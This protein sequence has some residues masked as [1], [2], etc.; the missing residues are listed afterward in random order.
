MSRITDYV[1]EPNI[2]YTNGSFLIKVKVQDDYKYKKYLVSENIK[3]KTISGTTFTLTDVKQGQPGSILQLEGNTT[4]Q[5]LPDNYQ[6]VEYIQSSGTQYID[7]GVSPTSDT[8]FTIEYQEG[9]GTGTKTLIGSGTS[10]AT[11]YIGISRN[12]TQIQAYWGNPNNV[13]LYTF[14]F[15]TKHKLKFNLNSD[16]KV[17]MDG[18]E[19]YTLA[20][21]PASTITTNTMTLFAFKYT[22]IVQYANA[23]KLYNCQ[24][25]SDSTLVRSF[26]PCYRKSDN[27]IGLYDL[28]TKAFFTNSGTGTF[29][30]GNNVT[31]NTPKPN[32][33]IDIST[34]S[35]D[36]EVVVCGKNKFNKNNA[37]IGKAWNNSSNTARAIVI[38]KVEPNTKY[39]ISFQSITGLELWWFGRANEND[40]TRTDGNYQITTSPT[41]ITTTAT[42]NYLGLQFN[43][44]NVAQSDIDNCNIQI[45]KRKPSN[46]LSSLYW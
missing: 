45:E 3:Y 10:T 40:S 6:E 32:T 2:V 12:G 44:T 17:V 8:G 38:T 42:T 21:N 37:Q 30:K 33:P 7:T 34:V 26:I 36:N 27:V 11:G 35:G 18:T 43:K 4:Q 13:T 29:T 46:N 14:T 9:T 41:T 19:I 20:T 16:R 31:D 25:Y 24:I 1:L 28:V 22:S 5:K 15:D 39:T 23:L